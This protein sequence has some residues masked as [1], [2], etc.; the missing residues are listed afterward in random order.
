MDDQRWIIHDWIPRAGAAGPCVAA[1][2]RPVAYFGGL[3]VDNVC[4]QTIGGVSV[5]CRDD[6][7][8]ARQWLKNLV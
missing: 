4:S 6:L 7:E 2:K 5:R 8:A 3:A 1:T